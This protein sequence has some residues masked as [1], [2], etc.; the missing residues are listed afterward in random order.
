MND[1]EGQ[2]TNGKQEEQPIEG[3]LRTGQLV[4][5]AIAELANIKG[6]QL[7]NMHLVRAI[8]EGVA[9]PTEKIL[10]DADMISI[11]NADYFEA[12]MRKQLGLPPVRETRQQAL[13][14]LGSEE[15]AA[16]TDW[17]NIPEC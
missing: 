4:N 8:L 11:A 3:K 1:N 10:Q 14:R 2:P 5:L 9:V 12:L 7:G 6:M 16:R 17:P 15:L 13:D